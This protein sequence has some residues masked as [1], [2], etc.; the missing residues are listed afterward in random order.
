MTLRGCPVLM[1]RVQYEL[2]RIYYNYYN[3]DTKKLIGAMQLKPREIKTFEVVFPDTA[4]DQVKKDIM[5]VL[6]KV[7]A[8]M[9][10]GVAVHWGPWKK[11]KFK[12]GAEIL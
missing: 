12:D 8:G 10:G 3:R 9:T 7:N 2:E 5:K 6:D 4:K 11:D 1:R